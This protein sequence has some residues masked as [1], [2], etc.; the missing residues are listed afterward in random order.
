MSEDGLGCPDICCKFTNVPEAYRN[1]DYRRIITA[2]RNG[3]IG[4]LAVSLWLESACRVP[5]MQIL[6]CNP[7]DGSC[8]RIECNR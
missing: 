5:G 3:E 1:L 4:S 2:F 6:T 8:D 7:L